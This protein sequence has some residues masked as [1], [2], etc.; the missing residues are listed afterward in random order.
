MTDIQYV[1]RQDIKTKKAN[2]RGSFHKKCGSK[3]K[4]C[5]LP[6]DYLT[7]KEKLNLN[8]GVETWNMSTFYSFQDF[9]KM[10]SDIQVEYIN[11]IIDK[12]SV[13]LKNVCE[14]VLK[15]SYSY[16]RKELIKNNIYGQIHIRSG[17][18]PKQ[19][20][21]KALKNDILMQ[22][23][24][25]PEDSVDDNSDV[26]TDNPKIPSMEA[27]GFTGKINETI[28]SMDG[29]DLETIQF[30]EKKYRDR[31]INV[32]ITVHVDE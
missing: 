23:G 30:L 31:K 10:P 4:K 24:E 2:G 1:Y 5:T 6:S 26:V 13:A 27:E 21:L 28:I 32:V 20:D 14:E 7:R 9:K 18:H 17:F 11:G 12:Y 25:T 16:F 3:S 19:E 22:T 15:V 8:S 29:F